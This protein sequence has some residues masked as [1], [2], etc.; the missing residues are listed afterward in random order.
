M[1][2]YLQPSNRR[3]KSSKTIWVVYG[4]LL[5]IAL[6]GFVLNKLAFMVGGPL[7]SMR[8]SVVENID[9]IGSYFDSKSSLEK[10]VSD[11]QQELDSKNAEIV[12]F[13]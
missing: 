10:R 1:M 2:T 8:S 5:C 7:W 3:G 11:L 4:T 9:T 13:V 6:L 12:G